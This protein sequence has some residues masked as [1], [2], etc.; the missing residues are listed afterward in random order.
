[1]KSNFIVPF[2]FGTGGIAGENCEN[3]GGTGMELEVRNENRQRDV[4]KKKEMPVQIIKRPGNELTIEYDKEQKMLKIKIWT[5][6]LVLPG[7]TL[8]GIG[9]LLLIIGMPILCLVT[10]IIGAVLFGM[11]NLS[12]IQKEEEKNDSIDREIEKRIG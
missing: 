4:E 1:M 12:N 10:C 7:L 6:L 8:L 3:K 9:G 2:F 11:S 5:P